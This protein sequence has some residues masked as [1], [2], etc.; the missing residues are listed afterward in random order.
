MSPALRSSPTSLHSL[1]LTFRSSSQP[2]TRSVFSHSGFSAVVVV[3]VVVVVAA[4]AAVAVVV[5]V[6]VV[7]VV[8]VVAVVVVVAAAVGVGVDVAAEVC[9]RVARVY[10]RRHLVTLI[11]SPCRIVG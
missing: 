7:A 10:Y 9:R 11:D 6:V 8:A 2:D 4:A 5:V 1:R 3:V